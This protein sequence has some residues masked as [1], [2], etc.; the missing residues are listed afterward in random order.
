M[1]P[2]RPSSPVAPVTPTMSRR[3]ALA[4]LGGGGRGLA[5]AA[6]AFEAPAQEASPPTGAGITAAELAPGVTIEVFAGVPS[7]R[8]AGHTLHLIRLVFQPGAEAGA[9]GHAGTVLFAVA[10]GAWEF[11]L[12]AGTARVLRGAAAGATG[13]AEELTEPGAEVVLNPGDAIT[14][15]EDVVHTARGAG[16][17]PAVVLGTLLLTAGEPIAMPADMDMGGTPAT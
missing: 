9:H 8:A 14:Y 3:R 7:T 4:G 11:T 10:S 5:L 13:P 6:R 15:E 1:Q 2:P 12:L 17:E 16:D